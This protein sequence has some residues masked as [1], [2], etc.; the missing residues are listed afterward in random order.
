MA[1][2]SRLPDGV[3]AQAFPDGTTDYKPIRSQKQDLRKPHITEYPITW[4]NWYK[5]VN[6]VNTTFIV[7]IPLLGFVSTYWTP[8]QLK[9]AVFALIYYFNAGLG[10][11]AGYHRLW[12]HTSYKASTPLKI[13]LA[14]MG[15]A[16]V[17][18]SIR[19]WSRG[20]RAHHRYTDTEKDPYSVRKG[21][22]YSHIG[23]MV[24]KQNPKRI[25]RS[26]ITDLN[27]DPVVIWQHTH[28][29]KSVIAM[30]LVFPTLVCG[31]GWGDWW[32]GFVYAGILRIFVVQQATFC[33]NSLAHW[34]GDQPFDDRN[35]PRDH[36]FTALVT[37]G[38]GYHN[39]HH[40]FPSDYRNAIEWW[41]Y[42]PTKWCIWSWQQVGLAS[43]LK[44][45]RSNE[46]EKGRVQQQQKKLDQRR[47]VLDW[48]TPLNELPVMGWDDFVEEAKNGRGLVSIA[49]VIHDVTDFIKDHPGGKAL[50]SSAIGK[51]ATAIFNG[52]VYLHSN[53]AHNLLS[54]M[55]VAVLRG[56]CEVEIWK[57]AQMEN[58]D[59]SAVYDAAGQRIMRAGDQPTRVAQPIASANAA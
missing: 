28:Y 32:G 5:H 37:L 19:W 11:T 23:W 22:L 49:G 30:A 1:S 53:A 4:G 34:L 40:E 18:G 20:H 33:V 13:Y 10:I 17:E 14:A 51:D 42:D 26:D 59:T 9:T 29:L 3:A 52:G 6:W 36:L 56:G 57:K 41:Q 7:F 25:G 2:A 48:G 45:F 16:A 47:A 44:Q 43:Q 15:A 55:R 8:L 50:I 31:L 24:M 27:E 58:K 21:L 35:S 12:A 46:I 39:F 54:T 38:E